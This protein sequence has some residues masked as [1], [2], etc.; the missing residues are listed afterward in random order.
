M[1]GITS[2]KAVQ[3]PNSSAYRSAPSTRPVVPR[4]HIPTPALVPITSER[5]AWPFT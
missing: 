4:I 5:I 2:M 3:T 1:Y